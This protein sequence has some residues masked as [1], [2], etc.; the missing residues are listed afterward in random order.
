MMCGLYEIVK[1]VVKVIASVNCTFYIN[2][3]DKKSQIDVFRLQTKLNK[4][5]IMKVLL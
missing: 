5:A 1:S 4:Y 2:V 3:I